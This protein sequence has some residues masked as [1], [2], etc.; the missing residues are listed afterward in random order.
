MSAA[1]ALAEL[2]RQEGAFTAW[3]RREIPGVRVYQRDQVY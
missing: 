1:Q 3:G 2:A